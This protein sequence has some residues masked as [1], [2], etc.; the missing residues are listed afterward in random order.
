MRLW[1]LVMLVIASVAFAIG[2][3]SLVNRDDDRG[4]VLDTDPQCF[5]AV[6]NGDGSMLP[7]RCSP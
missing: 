3:I 5:V 1:P 6:D 2:V 7:V 4:P